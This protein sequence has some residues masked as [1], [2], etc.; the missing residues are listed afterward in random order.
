MGIFDNYRK[1]WNLYYDVLA[2]FPLD[3]FSFTTSGEAHW[4]VLGYI[5]GNRLIWIRKVT[6]LMSHSFYDHVG[7]CVAEPE[8][9]C[10]YIPGLF[11]FQQKRK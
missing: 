11:V 7:H 10:S 2:V 5:R 8:H 1:S 6:S 3:L 9:K 4:R